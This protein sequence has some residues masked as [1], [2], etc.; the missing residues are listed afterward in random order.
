M[1]EIVYGAYRIIYFY[2]GK[3]VTILTVLHGARDLGACD[4]DEVEE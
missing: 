2:D 4:F 3:T 1:R